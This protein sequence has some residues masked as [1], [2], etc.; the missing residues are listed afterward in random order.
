MKHTWRK[1][2]KNLYIA[3]KKPVILNIPKMKY[4]SVEGSGNPNNNIEFSNNIEALYSLSY[5]IRMMPKSGYTPK[6]YYEYVVYPLEGIWSVKEGTKY[7]GIEDKDNFKYKIIIRQPEFVTEEI[8]KRSYAGV[9]EKGKV[10]MEILEKLVFEEIEEG[11]AVQILHIGSFDDE[12]KSFKLID[13]FIEEN[14]L[15]RNS[16]DHKEIYLSD[17]NRTKEENLKT[18]LRVWID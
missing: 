7:K 4:I 12:A 16:K 6:D 3:S 13:E 9:K 17:F 18:T 1:D 15:N 8:F 2:E 11:K 14:N 5:G 10:D